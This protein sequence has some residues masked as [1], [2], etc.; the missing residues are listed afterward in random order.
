[1]EINAVD[2]VFWVFITIVVIGGLACLV[3]FLPKEHDYEDSRQDCYRIQYRDGVY[4][5]TKK[6][7]SFGEN[8]YSIR[9]KYF[10]I[11][12]APFEADACCEDG[13]APDGKNYRAVTSVRVCFPEDKLQVFAPTFHNVSHESILE[14]V[15]EALAS[16]MKDALAKYDAAAGEEAFKEV[17]KE[18]AKEKLE[19][20]GIYVMTVGNIRVNENEK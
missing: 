4:S 17:F 15:E 20:F 11:K 14:T 3:V 8:K 19:I 13:K 9:S 12:K 5:V 6:K 16:A 18:C 2:I 7:P 1:M 10:Y